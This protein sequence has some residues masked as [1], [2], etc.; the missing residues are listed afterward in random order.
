MQGSLPLPA[1]ESPSQSVCINSRVQVRT[2][3][4]VRVVVAHGIP[5]HHYARQ[6]LVAEAYAV[7]TL[8]EDGLATVTELHRALGHARFTCYRWEKAYAAGGVMALAG[9][10]SGP[11]GPSVLG[12]AAA[13]RGRGY[14]GQGVHA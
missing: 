3:G 6:D 4:D 1:D 8:M 11:K 9:G 13:R 5:I 14:G 2:E 7:V 12:G 10:K